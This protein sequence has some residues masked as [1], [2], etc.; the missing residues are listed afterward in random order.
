MRRRSFLRTVFW[1]LD[2]Q[3]LAQER[4]YRRL[5][6]RVRGGE[7]PTDFAMTPD[8]ET[9]GAE[10]VARTAFGWSVAPLYGVLLILSLI[11]A[12]VVAQ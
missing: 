5:Y 8:A 3:Y 12:Q 11:L 2:A 6:D 10:T 1:L 7:G 9:R 4:W